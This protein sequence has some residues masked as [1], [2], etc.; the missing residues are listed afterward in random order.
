MSSL[1]DFRQAF[2]GLAE[3]ARLDTTAVPAEIST[4]LDYVFDPQ[5]FAASNGNRGVASAIVTIASSFS[6]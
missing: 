5:L 4:R 6:P 2:A 3:Q 1:N